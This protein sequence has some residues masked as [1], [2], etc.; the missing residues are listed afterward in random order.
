MQTWRT[1]DGKTMTFTAI[2]R[3]ANGRQVNGVA[4]YDKQ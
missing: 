1:I 2:L 4:V 3:D